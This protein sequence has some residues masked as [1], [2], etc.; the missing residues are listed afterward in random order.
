MEQQKIIKNIVVECKDIK[1]DERSFKH[2]IS[3]RAI[4]RDNDI[5]VPEKI[6]DN[7]YKLNPVV[8]FNHDMN[9][10]I[11][12][13]LWR[14]IDD[15]GYLGKTQFSKTLLGE[16]IFSLYRDGFLTSWSIGFYPKEEVKYIGDGNVREF[17]IIELLEYSAVTIPANPGAITLSFIKDLQSPELQM[18][19]VNEYILQNIQED[20]EKLKQYELGNFI[21]KSEHDEII[22]CIKLENE[23]IYNKI[24]QIVADMSFV[25]E[26]RKELLLKKIKSEIVCGATR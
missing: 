14:K 20:V 18:N 26:F 2:Y 5:I 22:N 4:D 25:K 17:G 23:T 15:T 13:N 16:E 24:D 1:E 6:D 12:K 21:T 9:K 3:T 7:N 8:L 11:A 19:Y 10:P